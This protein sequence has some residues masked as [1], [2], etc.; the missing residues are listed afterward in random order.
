MIT[1]YMLEGTDFFHDGP[2][3]HH[4]CVTRTRQSVLDHEV[5]GLAAHETIAVPDESIPSILD[6]NTI[7]EASSDGL[8]VL[9]I[10]CCLYFNHVIVC[11][12]GLSS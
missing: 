8:Q 4:G 5:D 1:C 2:P 9:N 11:V 3:Q 6:F 10:D 7:S 12:V